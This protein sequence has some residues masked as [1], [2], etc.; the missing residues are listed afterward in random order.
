MY[1]VIEFMKS[2]KVR[3]NLDNDSRG[4]LRPQ[5]DIVAHLLFHREIR[6]E[7]SAEAFLSPRFDVGLHNPFLLKDMDVAVKRIISAIKKGERVC[8]FSDYDADGIPGGVVL[9]DFFKMAGFVNFFNYIP[10]RQEEGFGLKKESIEK[11]VK[12]GAVLLITIDCGTTDVLEI[13][14]AKELGLEVIVTDHHESGDIL[15]DALAIINPKVSPDYPFKML[16]GAGVIFKVIQAILEKEDFGIKKGQEKWLLD[17]VGIATLSDMVPLVDENRIFSY[18]GLLVLQKSKRLGL[19]KLLKKLKINQKTLTEDDVAF[20]ITPRINA[21]SRMGYSFDAF[22]LLTAENDSEVDYLVE[23]LEK[24]NNE[25]K[26]TT[27]YLTKEVRKM[28]EAK[29]SPYFNNKV[30]VAGS[31]SWQPSILGLVA[32]SLAESEMK[33]VFLWGKE[34][35]TESLKGSCRSDGSVSVVHLMSAV[36]EGVFVDFGGHHGAGGFSVSYDSVHL[37][38]D[39]LSKVFEKVKKEEKEEVDWVDMEF[40]ASDIDERILLSFEKLAPFGIGNSK[41]KVLVKGAFVTEVGF[42][43]KEKNHLK[44][45]I[46]KENKRDIEAICFFVSEDWIKRFE[47]GRK[48]DLICNIERNFFGG[49]RFRLRIV[50]I[51]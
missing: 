28:I 24:I 27:A 37:L 12:E 43:G 6:D 1:N 45:K 8:I 50:D 33:P 40:L 41:P 5:N 14:Y 10:D 3:E 16:C 11:I 26:G 18:F 7:L 13:A 21:A 17:M 36:S 44:I 42:F 2:Y 47:V 30:I 32:G 29:Y 31:P 23:H 39:E 46:K 34:G 38:E 9:H 15:P 4:L 25:R 51:M 22:K 20:M 19:I 49:N 35:S 48:M